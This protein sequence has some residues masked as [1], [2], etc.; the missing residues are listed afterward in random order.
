MQR[1]INDELEDMDLKDKRLVKRLGMLLDSFTKKPSCS[2]PKACESQAKTKGAYRFFGNERVEADKIREGF[3]KK[4]AKR[5]SKFK[6]VL[7][8]SDGSD[9]CYTSH[10]KLE[11]RGALKKSFML[12]C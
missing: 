11:G 2:I 12:L 3:F 6:T 1:W 8:I 9:F 5:A 10:E 4:T 7:A